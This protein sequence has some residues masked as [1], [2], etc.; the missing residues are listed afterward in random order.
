MY[1]WRSSLFLAAIAWF[2]SVSVASWKLCHWYERESVALEKSLVSTFLFLKNSSLPFFTLF[3]PF[4][5]LFLFSSMFFPIW[6]NFSSCHHSILPSFLPCSLGLKQFL[7]LDFLYLIPPPL[8][9]SLSLLFV[10]PFAILLHLLSSLSFVLQQFLHPSLYFYCP[11]CIFVFFIHFVSLYFLYCIHFLS[12]LF[13]YPVII[14]LPKKDNL[15]LSYWVL[16]CL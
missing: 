14:S 6:F 9:L 3:V 13:V 12:T 16:G 15:A 5:P 8:S 1:V 2:E 7:F 10:W 11:F 4:V